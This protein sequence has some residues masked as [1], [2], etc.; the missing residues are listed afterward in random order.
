MVKHGKLKELESLNNDRIHEEKEEMQKRQQQADEE[1]KQAQKMLSIMKDSE[2]A[3]SNSSLSG[4][5]IAGIPESSTSLPAEKTRQLLAQSKSLSLSMFQR[6]IETHWPEDQGLDKLG[7]TLGRFQS[8]A[9]L[10]N[11]K[12][13][14]R[15][16]VHYMD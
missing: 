4:L 13:R 12:K 9:K 16:S 15:V 11:D 8:Q 14:K 7:P 2:S 6:V 3:S 10:R 1:R 5:K